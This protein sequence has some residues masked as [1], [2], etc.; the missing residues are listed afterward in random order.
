M[1]AVEGTNSDCS[2]VSC[3]WGENLEGVRN[4]GRTF[5][6]GDNKFVWSPHVYTGDVTGNWVYSDTSFSAHWGYLAEN[7]ATNEAALVIG[8]FGTRNELTWLGDLADYLISIDQRNHFFWCLNPNSGDTG[9]LLQSDWTTEE[10][11]KLTVLDRIQPNPSTITS[12]NTR[13]CIS[14]LGDSGDGGSSPVSSPVEPPVSSPVTPPVSSPVSPPTSP[15]VSSG[16]GPITITQNNGCSQWWCALN[17]ASS[18]LS[19]MSKLEYRDSTYTSWQT[20]TKTSWGY[21]IPRSGGAFSGSQHYR[22]TTSG[23]RKANW[24]VFSGINPGQSAQL[25]TASSFT[26]ED[27]VGGSS[28]TWAGLAAI[29]ICSLLCVLC[30]GCGVWYYKREG[31]NKGEAS[32]QSTAADTPEPKG[33]DTPQATNNEAEAEIE[34]EMN[35][36]Q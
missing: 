33:N 4:T 21:T 17:I 11:A 3:C 32:F 30:I 10:T 9:G 16:S 1:I 8:E 6:K 27:T 15:P 28:L 18:D 36:Q 5:T 14:G 19:R 13:V 31:I 26:E 23:G 20:C 24:N 7:H 22:V 12:T 35:T 25:T 29:I 2:V 34:V